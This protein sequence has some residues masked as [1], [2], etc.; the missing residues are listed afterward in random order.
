[1][2]GGE[3]GAAE[4]V[5]GHHRHGAGGAGKGRAGLEPAGRHLPPYVTGRAAPEGPAEH[6]EDLVVEG[7]PVAQEPVVA[8]RPSGGDGG[9]GAGRGGG[10]HRGDGPLDAVGTGQGGGQ[11]RPGPE[12]LPAQAVE[13]QEDHLVGTTGHVGKPVGVGV[14]RVL[15]GDEGGD[16]VGDAGAPVVGEERGRRVGGAAGGRWRIGHSCRH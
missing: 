7:Q 4:L 13:D 15:A 1:M 12:L 3:P 5:L 10:G 9:E 11:R 2:G 16:D 8:R 6:V 14:G